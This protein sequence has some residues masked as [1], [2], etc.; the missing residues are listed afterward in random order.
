MYL[1]LLLVPAHLTD[2]LSLA[3]YRI[4]VFDIYK[5]ENTQNTFLYLKKNIYLHVYTKFFII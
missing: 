2:E 4:I 5:Y 1:F 3:N